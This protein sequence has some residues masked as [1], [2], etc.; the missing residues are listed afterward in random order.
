MAKNRDSRLCIYLCFPFVNSVFKNE[1]SI[2]K[3]S[4]VNYFRDDEVYLRE[5]DDDND[6][7][8]DR[9][10]HSIS[11]SST[12]LPFTPLCTLISARSD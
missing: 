5:S 9:L 1:R 3:Y 4:K 7:A 8:S 6:D 10:S 12:P 11:S 2:D